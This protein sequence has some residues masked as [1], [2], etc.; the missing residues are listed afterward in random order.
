MGYDRW[1]YKEKNS[2]DKSRDD[3]R[4]FEKE[5]EKVH[6]EDENHGRRDM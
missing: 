1:V 4:D 5:E 3:T 6:R 2:E